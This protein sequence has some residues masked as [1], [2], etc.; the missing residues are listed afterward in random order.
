MIVDHGDG[1]KSLYA[2]MNRIDVGVGNM[3]NASMIIGTVGLTGR[4]TGPHVHIE[5]I[6]NGI[7]VDPASVL[8]D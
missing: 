5:I 4:T 7:Q 2:H 3:V 6:D 1:L 8:P